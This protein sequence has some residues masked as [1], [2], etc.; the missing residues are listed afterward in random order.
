M[1]ARRAWVRALAATVL[2][3]FALQLAWISLAEE[4]YPALMMPRFAEAGPA[5]VTEIV[6]TKPVISMSYADGTTREM[7]QAELLSP[8]PEGHHN[9]IMWVLLSER[10]PPAPARK[11]VGWLEGLAILPGFHLGQT[12]RD[13]SE[14]RLSLA[15]WLGR[16]ASA[17]YGGAPPTRCRVDWVEETHATGLLARGEP[18]A[19]RVGRFEIELP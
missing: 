3:A 8:V 14:H 18:Q 12:A 2:A 7:T 9:K 1:A 6:I 15:S 4:P 11:L 10:Q 17:V 13:T 19:R 16:R 5:Q